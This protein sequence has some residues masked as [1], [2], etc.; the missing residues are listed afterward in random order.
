MIAGPIIIRIGGLFPWTLTLISYCALLGVA[1]GFGI[2]F[3]LVGV[4]QGGFIMGVFYGLMYFGTIIGYIT[5]RLTYEHNRETYYKYIRNQEDLSNPEKSV[6]SYIDYLDEL[7]IRKA[8][9]EAAKTKKY[10]T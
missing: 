9:K 8:E 1:V 2:E 7:R 10:A 5:T 6:Q 4:M 3:V